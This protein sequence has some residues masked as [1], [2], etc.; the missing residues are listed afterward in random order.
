ME[1]NKKDF[2]DDLMNVQSRMNDCLLP[3]ERTI[4]MLA[5]E[6]GIS[7]TQ[8]KR[9]LS[10]LKKKNLVTSRRIT[11]NGISRMAYIITEEYTHNHA[12]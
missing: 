5:K 10:I 9:K 12:P 11:L 3:E 8:I 6:Y 4:E 7:E 2:W 1:N